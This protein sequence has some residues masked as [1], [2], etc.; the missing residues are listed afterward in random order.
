MRRKILT[1][2]LLTAV[3]ALLLCVGAAAADEYD[4]WVNGV[5][6]TSANADDVLGNADEG[7]TVKYDAV[8]NT[9][10]LDGA[11]LTT[12]HTGSNNHAGV[13]YAE[14][15]DAL[16][17]NVVGDISIVTSGTGDISGIYLGPVSENADPRESS[18]VLTG[19]AALDITINQKGTAVRARND[20]T[21]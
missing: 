5:Q 21:V 6:V 13:I 2:V 4:L 14:Y 20:I 16:T 3:F 8:T 9:L 7:A 18:V 11:E 15:L 17:I 12:A 1:L 10:T 19:D